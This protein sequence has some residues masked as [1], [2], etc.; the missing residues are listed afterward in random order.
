MA[1]PEERDRHLHDLSPTITCAIAC[2]LDVLLI[3]T[4][5]F[6][7]WEES[8]RFSTSKHTIVG[9]VAAAVIAVGAGL[10][11]SAT[12]AAAPGDTP[13]NVTSQAT[14]QAV[15]NLGLN[16]RQA[17]G[18]QRHLQ[19]RGYNPGTIDGY[20]GTDSWKAMQRSLRDYH[21]YTGAI[22]GIV[23]PNTIKALQRMLKEF[24]GYTGAI[25]GIAGDGTRAAWARCGSAWADH[26]GY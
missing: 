2:L 13:L 12:A 10:G 24:Y 11:A 20:L 8:M 17:K 25:D 16:A 4:C 1:E 22:D 3:Q 14:S 19:V 26:Y 7:G 6:Y 15:E 21:G 9:G 23:G 5:S 18:I